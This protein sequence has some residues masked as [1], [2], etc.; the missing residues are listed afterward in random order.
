MISKVLPPCVVSVEKFG[1]HSGSLWNEEASALGR[2]VE[3]RRQE[4]AAGRTCARIA[5]ATLGVPVQPILRGSQR[6]P[7][8]PEGIVGSITHCEGYAVAAVARSSDIV[9]VG[10]DVEPNQPLPEDVLGVIARQ[11][12]IES[13][14]RI[15]TPPICWDRLLF[16]AKES[17]YKAWYPLTKCWLG[18]DEV[19]LA[20]DPDRGRFKARI[21]ATTS[22]MQ[23]FR[24]FQIRGRFLVQQDYI[25]TS[26]IIA[27]ATARLARRLK[28]ESDTLASSAT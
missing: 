10:I 13:L 11:E 5:L 2:A 28:K 8:W 22:H 3:S 21:L 17:I 23:R 18:F 27:S 25:V 4:F 16:S 20:L 9:S 1:R 7:L 26:V 19:S 24:G 14:P 6:E 15:S 12:E